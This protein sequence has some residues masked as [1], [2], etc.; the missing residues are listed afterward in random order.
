MSPLLLD[1]R[2]RTTRY[3]QIF[4]D[5]LPPYRRTTDIHDVERFFER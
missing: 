1:P 5:S 4:L 2:I 3:G